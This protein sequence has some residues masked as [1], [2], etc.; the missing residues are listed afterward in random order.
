MFEPILSIF[1]GQQWEDTFTPVIRIIIGDIEYGISWSSKLEE[2]KNE[3]IKERFKL[4]VGNIIKYCLRDATKVYCLMNPNLRDIDNNTVV[5]S[6]V[7][8]HKISP[9]LVVSTVDNGVK[10]VSGYSSRSI[11]NKI[12][13]E[14]PNKIHTKLYNYESGKYEKDKLAEIQISEAIKS[15]K[16]DLTTSGQWKN[17][18][19]TEK[20][21]SKPSVGS[22]KPA[23]RGKRKITFEEVTSELK[24]AF[25]A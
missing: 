13:V 23:A 25:Y 19:A 10:T 6:S 1:K 14:S 22:K 15:L 2:E 9:V 24:S 3:E 20:V 21:V 18:R 16:Q 4:S 7:V 5:I 8:N 17:I 12:F 11:K